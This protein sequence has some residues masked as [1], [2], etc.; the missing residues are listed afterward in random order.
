MSQGR[1]SQEELHA[2]FVAVLERDGFT[3]EDIQRA[4]GVTASV[5]ARYVR[6]WTRTGIAELARREGHRRYFRIAAHARGDIAEQRIREAMIGA[7][8]PIGNMWRSMRMMAEFSPTDIA[9]HSCTDETP[10]TEAD[11]AAYC[12]TLVVAGY[13][14]V[15]RKAIPGQ[16]TATYRLIR[17]TGPRPPRE[18][19]VRAVYD[20]NLGQFTHVNGGPA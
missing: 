4:C 1:T 8:S 19:R 18:R 7:Q 10:V 6:N 16:R 9:A 14:R 15:V 5:A 20:D 2:A 12:R 11:A 13:L 17:N 3:A